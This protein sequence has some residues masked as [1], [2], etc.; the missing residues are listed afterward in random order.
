MTPAVL[1]SAR[2]YEYVL[3]P[4]PVPLPLDRPQDT[5]VLQVSC[6]RAHSLILTDREGGERACSGFPGEWGSR[7]V[8]L[9]STVARLLEPHLISEAVGTSPASR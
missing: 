6:G 1:V 9:G 7:A 8:A 2:G 4:S 5:Q 3:E